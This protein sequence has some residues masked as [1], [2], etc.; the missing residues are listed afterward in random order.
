MGIIADD[1]DLHMRH[2]VIRGGGFRLQ[3]ECPASAFFSIIA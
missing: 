1:I 2:G 3:Q